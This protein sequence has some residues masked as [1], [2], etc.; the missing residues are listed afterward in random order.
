MLDNTTEETWVKHTFCQTSWE[1][2]SPVSTHQ[3]WRALQTAE[4]E[5]TAAESWR[6]QMRKKHSGIDEV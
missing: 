4:L 3:R 2:S 6:R 1:T 5:V